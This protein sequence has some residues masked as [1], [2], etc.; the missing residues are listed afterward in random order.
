MEQPNG[1]ITQGQLYERVD[2]VEQRMLA[3]IDK[4]EE[5]FDTLSSKVDHILGWGAAM[6]AVAGVVVAFVKDMFVKQ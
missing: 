6:G 3:R 1:R 2:I 4:L 5:K